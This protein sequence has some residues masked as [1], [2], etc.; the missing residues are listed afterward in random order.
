PM[1]GHVPALPCTPL[2][3]HHLSRRHQQ[4]GR[5]SPRG[6]AQALLLLEP[7]EDR[8]L[9]ASYYVAP[10]GSP[11]LGDGSLRRPRATLAHAT[12]ATPEGASEVVL[13]DGTYGPRS[14]STSFNQLLTVRAQDPYRAEW[15]SSA[16]TRRAL[17]VYGA[18]NVTLSGFEIKGQP[19]GTDDYLIQIT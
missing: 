19:G 3:G 10:L 13:L 9:P 4:G 1:T 5:A 16:T 15:I 14:I 11:G 12:A 8:L 6:R 18:A 7:L 17:G 2:Q